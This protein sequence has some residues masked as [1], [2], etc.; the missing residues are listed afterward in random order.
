MFSTLVSQFLPFKNLV[1]LWRTFKNYQV[2]IIVLVALGILGATLDGIGINAVI[3]LISF[4]TSAGSGPTDFISRAIQTLFAFL[5]IPFTFR[6]LLVFILAL[7]FS[8]AVV[9]TLSGYIR[10]WISADFLGK[11]SESML[12]RMLNASWPFLLKQ[13]IGTL[14]ATL[15]RDI[16]R[17]ENLLQ[18]FGQIIQSFSGFLIYLLIAFNISPSITLY[19]LVVGAILL[20]IVRPLLSRSQA[21]ANLLVATEKNY[22]HFLSEHIMGAKAFKAAGVEK[23]ALQSGG[24]LLQKMRRLSIQSTLI[25]S[26]SSSLFQP[27]SLIFVIVLFSIVYRQPGFSMI[28]FA[29]TL[30][31]IQKIFTYLES[32]H[33]ALHS[34]RETIPYTQNIEGFKKVLDEHR[35]TT[36]PG[37]APFSFKRKLEFRN[38]S[39]SY[40]EGENVLSDVNFSIL[41]GETIGLIGPSGAGKTSVADLLLRLFKPTGGDILIDGKPF[42]AISSESWRR[43]IGYVAQDVFLL[44]A[45]IEDNIRFYR[46]SLSTEAIIEATKQANIYNF[47]IGLP[48][49]FN[50]MTGDRGVMLSGG[51]RQRIALA[52]ALAG[53]PALLILDEA[54]SALD[55]ES[56][57]LIHESIRAL[58]GKITVVIVAHRPST[59]AEA[60][61]ILALSN[62]RI[63]ENGTP[64]E[65]L[66]NHDSYFYKMQRT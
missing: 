18:V 50:T 22:T 29:A 59:V 49:G 47:I 57:K 23:Y 45:S 61:K 12:G 21:I 2:Q 34:I 3:P 25:R 56:E 35:E 32:G 8:R 63:I 37:A 51:Q 1:V 27:A 5:H 65:L 52:R 24:T 62:G 6:Y 16:Q 33:G 58:H 17:T 30:Y 28:S 64:E 20:L 42:A 36:I 9:M 40:G 13:K 55:H 11:E 19:T 46:P 4:Y 38:V 31:L 66:K 54:T 53:R 39:F 14:Q 7:F 41:K 26:M 10:G 15:V 44:N 43:N 60:D 48:D